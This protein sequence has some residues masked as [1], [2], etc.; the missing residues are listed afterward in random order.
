MTRS[1]PLLIVVLFALG[2]CKTAPEARDDP[3]PADAY[4]TVPTQESLQVTA[5]EDAA[6][7]EQEEADAAAAAAAAAAK[8]PQ[9]AEADKTFVDEA[10][11]GGMAEVELSQ[12]ALE[13]AKKKT[14]K[15]LA[16]KMVDDHGKANAELAALCNTRGI[17]LPTELDEA[18]KTR[19]AELEK[20]TGS[21]FEKAYV[22]IMLEDHRKAVELFRIESQSGGDPELKQ[23]AGATLPKLEE[24]L[25]HVEHMA[26]GKTYKPKPPAQ[27]SAE[28]AAPTKP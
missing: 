3:A 2:S 26:A 17:A 22:D 15:D 5:N 19:K 27:A 4:S 1:A 12:L 9:L 21:K 24:H 20:K 23:W 13:R 28:T 10:A 18:A 25:S 11:K 14:V 6:R 16:Q 7:R 8:P